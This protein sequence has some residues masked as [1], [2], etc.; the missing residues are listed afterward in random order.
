MT[1]NEAENPNVVVKVDTRTPEEI[2]KSIET[3]GKIVSKSLA[4]LKTLLSSS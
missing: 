1:Y 4:K 3:Q 2:I